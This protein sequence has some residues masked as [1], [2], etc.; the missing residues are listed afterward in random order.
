[1]TVI[2]EANWA[3][4]T[5]AISGVNIRKNYE[6]NR[7]CHKFSLKFPLGSDPSSS[8]VQLLAGKMVKTDWLFGPASILKSRC[9]IYPCHRYRC[10]LPCPCKSCCKSSTS[11]CQVPQHQTCPCDLCIEQYKDH[12]IFHRT[13]HFGCKF[14]VQLVKII[15]NFNFWFLNSGRRLILDYYSP[16]EHFSVKGLVINSLPKPIIQNPNEAKYFKDYDGYYEHAKKCNDLCNLLTCEEC[17]YAVKNIEQFK[18]HIQLNHQVS[19]RFYHCYVD[20]RVT[21]KQFK[22]DM[23]SEVFKI[24]KDLT[25]HLLDKHYEKTYDCD[26]CEEVFKRLDNLNRHIKTMHN[27]TDNKFACTHCGKQ[28]N[29][30]DALKRHSKV[31]EIAASDFKCDECNLNFCNS[32][33]LRSHTNA[34][35]IGL[36]CKDCNKTFTLKQS[37]EYHIISKQIVSCNDCNKTFCN[38]NALNSHK[39]NVHVHPSVECD[40][41]GQ[42]CLVSNI[43]YHKVWAHTH[44]KK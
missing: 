10:Q 28:F 13:F 2:Y 44:A 25:R 27:E 41:C 23:C 22:C 7:M 12:S 31:H 6:M 5:L 34:Q 20:T 42:M 21:D 18:E 40:V 26:L 17:N 3:A 8:K 11:V 9:V 43:M 38:K 39:K 32:K 30:K 16:R 29:R 4:D 19:K 24:N 37:L 15:P 36:S 1:M 33:L 35:H 14:C